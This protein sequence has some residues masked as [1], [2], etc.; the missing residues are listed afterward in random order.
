MKQSIVFFDSE[1]E[2]GN[3]FWILSK[4]SQILNNR[5]KSMEMI[6]RT[7]H[8]QNYKEALNVISEYVELFDTAGKY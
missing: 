6:S 1:G 4:A 2:T 7:I 3:I 8:Q 5:K